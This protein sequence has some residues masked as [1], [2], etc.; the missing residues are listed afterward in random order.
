[1]L[2]ILTITLIAGG[3]SLI[4]TLLGGIIGTLFKGKNNLMISS[5]MSIAAGLMI[6]VVTFDLIPEAI[7]MG[8]ITQALIGIVIGV[9][10]ISLVDVF[11]PS[12]NIIKSRGSHIKTSILLGISL[13]AHNFPEGIAIGASFAAGQSL[14]IGLC[15]VIG[16]HDI[17][18][19]A[20]VAAPLLKSSLSKGRIIL[21][22][23]LTALP[24]AIGGLCG[25]LIADVSR[26]FISISLGFAGGTML[27][28]VCGELIPESK[29]LFKGVFSTISVI[30]GIVLGLIITT[31]V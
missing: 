11:L 2:K 16:L 23:A 25:V 6:S 9:V 8:G 10:F 7:H 21:L 30:I 26:M 12:T 17:P 4:G 3:V 22:T 31:I 29:N 13:A 1:M 14:G 5:I 28:I 20:A 24:T 18:E 27:Y 19:G 15:I